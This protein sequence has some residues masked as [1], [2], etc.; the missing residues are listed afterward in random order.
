MERQAGLTDSDCLVS[1]VA[2]EPDQPRTDS[3]VLFSEVEAVAAGWMLDF[4]CRCLCRHFCEDNRR[5]FERSCDLLLTIIKGLRRTEAQQ[6]KAICIC[7][8][9]VCVAEGKSLDSHF[10]SDQ[11]IS[12][13]ENALSAW[14]SL[15][16]VQ[17]IQDKLHEEI[18]H[19]I[20]I[21]PLRMKLAAI[22]KQKDPYHQFLL[23]FSF[24]LLTEKIKS[25]VRMFLNEESDNFL[26]KEATK[27]AKTKKSGQMLT[28]VQCNSESEPAAK[29]FL[30]SMQR[31][32]KESCSLTGQAFWNLGQ[33]WCP[34]KTRITKWK[35]LQSKKVLQ[36][37]ENT[38]EGDRCLP[39]GQK[40][41]RW[42]FEEDKKLKD[43]VQKF[44]V[45]NWTQILQHYGFNNR[46]NVMLKDRWRTMVRLGIA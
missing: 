22:T 24:S 45:G 8:L 25:Y 32:Q 4:A 11:T 46:T 7:Q 14:T 19:L 26:M 33:I 13:L 12:P 36:S 6:V 34:H 27:E 9:L 18:K 30:E 41:R 38:Q 44:G 43:G 15:Q 3:P 10:G 37:I 17:S 16:K 29:K 5:D 42:S 40:K 21:Q 23:H 35:G 20:Q 2:A 39:A 31:L 28:D 1:P